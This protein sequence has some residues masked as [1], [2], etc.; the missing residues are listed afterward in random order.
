[1]ATPTNVAKCQ[2]YVQDGGIQTDSNDI[3]VV[4]IA[5]ISNFQLL[6]YFLS[7]IISFT[8]WLNSENGGLI[9]QNLF[10]ACLQA[11]ML[12]FPVWRMPSLNSGFR[13]HLTVNSFDKGLLEIPQA[14]NS[15]L[16]V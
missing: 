12:P 7:V 1:M 16:G 8:E 15:G 14:E 10:Q 2:N 5:S 13:F 3:Y 9:V 11:D 6:V 4:P